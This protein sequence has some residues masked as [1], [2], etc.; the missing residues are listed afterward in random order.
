M[1]GEDLVGAGECRRAVGHDEAGN[2]VAPGEQPG[3]Q[4][5]LRR[6]VEGRAQIVEEEELGLPQEHP[7]RGGALNLPAGELHAARADERVEAALSSALDTETEAELW[8]R[9]FAR[10]SE[11]TCL[12]VT[13][14][15]TALRRADQ[16]LTLE[17]GRLRITKGQK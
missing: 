10:P 16:I 4:L 15:P 12:V 14:R 17:D 1:E 9:L 8:Q 5:R 2:A 3:P 11:Q 7:R 6:G 13:H